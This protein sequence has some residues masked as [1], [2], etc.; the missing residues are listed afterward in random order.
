MDFL[1]FYKL[2]EHPFSSSIDNRF[3]FNSSQH[4]EALLRL[5]YAVDTMKG[6]AVVV[7]GVGTGKST[8]ARRMLDELDDTVYE[9]ALL[10]VLHTSVTTD[11][12]MKKIAMQLGVKNIGSSKLE[13]LGQVARKLHA[14]HDSGLKTVIL[15]DEVQMLKSREIMEEFRGLLNMEVSEGKLITLVLFGLPEL[16]DVLSLDLPLKQRISV[17]YKLKGFE[18]KITEEYIK[19]RIKVAACPQGIFA[20]EAVQAVHYYSRGVPRLINTICDNAI[21]EGFLVK[22]NPIGRDIIESVAQSLD[23]QPTDEEAEEYRHFG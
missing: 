12:L 1:E 22:A 8:L 15:V 5:K 6:L 23:L 10:I 21:F 18:Q 7:G 20:S 13:V 17:K 2:S 14:I 4:A 16:E 3:Y 19:H 9:A 11:W